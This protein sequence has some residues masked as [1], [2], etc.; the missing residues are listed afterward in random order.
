MWVGRAGPQ[1]PLCPRGELCWVELEA[2]AAF[3]SFSSCFPQV[4]L[5]LGLFCA[6]CCLEKTNA[7][8]LAGS[9]ALPK[10]TNG[11]QSQVSNHHFSLKKKKK[12]MIFPLQETKFDFRRFF[13]L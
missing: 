1:S 2:V 13:T 11:G 12:E 7:I 10:Q 9:A 4:P 3:S 8:G 5:L 6:F